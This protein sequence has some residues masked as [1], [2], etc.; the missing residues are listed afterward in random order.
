MSMNLV[1]ITC[2]MNFKLELYFFFITPLIPGIILGKWHTLNKYD[3]IHY[4]VMK[5]VTYIWCEKIE[6]L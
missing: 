5:L 3:I 6:T 2:Y 4:F 1:L